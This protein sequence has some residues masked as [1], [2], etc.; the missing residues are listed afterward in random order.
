MRP[1]PMVVA[2]GVA[3]LVP[4][5][6]SAQTQCLSTQPGPINGQPWVCVNGGWLPPG[7]APTPPPP[8]STVNP[9]TSPNQP[10]P[11]V[12]FR[13]GRRY[14]RGDTD[15]YIMALTQLEN[16]VHVYMAQCLAVA[17]GCFAVGYFRAILTN[18]SAAIEQRSLDERCCAHHRL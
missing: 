4:G 7:S 1:V 18:A 15:I 2:L 10:T 8:P 3:L 12:P 5:L 9:P 11:A 13:T 16:G 14:V 17:D 6:A